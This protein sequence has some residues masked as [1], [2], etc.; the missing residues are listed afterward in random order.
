MTHLFETHFKQKAFFDD[1]NLE[2]L[3][4]LQR[5]HHSSV[6]EAGGPVPLLC[7]TDWV[8]ERAVSLKGSCDSAE[9]YYDTTLIKCHFHCLLLSPTRQKPCS[10][11]CELVS[12]NIDNS[13]YY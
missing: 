13:A 12:L 6:E 8:F 3:F 10:K 2:R 7:H 11:P 4:A 5:S 1:L 9:G